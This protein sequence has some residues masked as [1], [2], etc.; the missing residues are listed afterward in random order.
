MPQPTAWDVQAAIGEPR[1]VIRVRGLQATLGPGAGQDAWGRNG[2]PQPAVLSA[3]A[4]LAAP[5]PEA[6]NTDQVAGDTV[7]YGTLSKAV[8]KSLKRWDEER[9]P[10]GLLHVLDGLWIDLT[11]RMATGA[12]PSSPDAP[13]SQDPSQNPPL[14]S[15][16]VVRSLSVTVLLPKATLV[17]EG[18]SL[19]SAGVLAR[20]AKGTAP[21]ASNTLRLHRLRVPTLVGVHPHERTAKQAVVADIALD[22]FTEY[23]DVYTRLEAFVVQILETSEFETLEALATHIARLILLRFRPNGPFPGPDLPPWYVHVSLEKP[24]AV[25]SADAPVV[26]VRMGAEHL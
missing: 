11:G 15:A 16:S 22:R 4:V 13:P 18:V 19:T 14:L 2:R 26:E 6:A 25:P 8:L 23:E 12:K 7:H 10:T 3:E 9:P 24:I 5:F 1:A 21:I 17:G 20:A